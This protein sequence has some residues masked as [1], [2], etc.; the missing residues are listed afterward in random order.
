M[1]NTFCKKGEKAFSTQAK[2]E[3]TWKRRSVF[4]SFFPHMRKMAPPML[5][6]F[7]KP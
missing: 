7:L 5:V 2:K 3:K 4:L 1:G 6:N